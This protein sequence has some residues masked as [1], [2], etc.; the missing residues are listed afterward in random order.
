METARNILEAIIK[1]SPGLKKT[2]RGLKAAEHWREIAD[3]DEKSWIT[4]YSMGTLKVSTEDPGFCQDT[5]FKKN[6]IIKELNDRAGEKYIKDIKI[7]V[8]SREKEETN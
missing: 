2:L 8:G 5:H 4:G 6:E 7:K 3:P 1:K